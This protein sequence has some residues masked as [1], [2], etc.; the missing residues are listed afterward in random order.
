[1]EVY[2]K[3][4]LLELIWWTWC[5]PQTLLG[6]ILNLIFKGEEKTITY[7]MKKYTYYNTTLKPGSISL[8]K[9]ILLC[10]SHHDDIDTIQHEHGHQIQ[11][12]ILGPLY[13]LVISLPSLIWCGCFEKYREKHYKSY[14]DFYTERWA[15]NLA[16]VGIL[17]VI[18][19]II[20]N[21]EDNPWFY[22]YELRDKDGHIIVGGDLHTILDSKFRTNTVVDMFEDS[23]DN[24]VYVLV[25]E[26]DP[27]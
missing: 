8:G 24:E 12:L 21:T 7:R 2:M 6:F 9:Y 16:Y 26:V 19:A 18:E 20:L 25:I 15:D 4:I 22:H 14:Y 27:E 13:L 23:T 3:E 10:D 11:S 5:L 1:M 17:S